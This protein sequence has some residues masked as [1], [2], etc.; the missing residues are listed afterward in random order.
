M[1]L[2]EAHRGSTALQQI[3]AAS[4]SNRAPDPGTEFVTARFRFEYLDG[5]NNPTPY[6]PN[7]AD[8]TAVSSAGIDYVAAFVTPPSPVL[9]GTITPGVS[10]EGWVAFEVAT[11]DPKPVLAFNKDVNSHGG[12]WWALPAEGT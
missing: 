1:T 9:G 2:L 7:P 12:L 3:Q 8:F 10:T 5:G 6:K 11:N 4:P